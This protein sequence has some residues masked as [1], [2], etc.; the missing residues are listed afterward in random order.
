MSNA[1]RGER[2]AC[3]LA[4]VHISF[5]HVLVF[6]VP[7]SPCGCGDY[8]V[9]VEIVLMMAHSCAYSLHY[10]RAVRRASHAVRYRCIHASS[11]E[12][13]VA[14]Q[15]LRIICTDHDLYGSEESAF[16]QQL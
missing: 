6:A 3:N 1:E 15:I 9:K 12:L 8:H 2:T 5:G 16:S 7:V 13:S 10:R 11:S 14:D 4:R